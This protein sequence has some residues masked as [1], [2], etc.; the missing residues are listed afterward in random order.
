[1]ENVFREMPLLLVFTSFG[2]LLQV[3]TDTF[4]ILIAKYINTRTMVLKMVRLETKY[5]YSRQVSKVI[6]NGKFIVIF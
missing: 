3:Q 5:K 4:T 6:F 1:M 2:L